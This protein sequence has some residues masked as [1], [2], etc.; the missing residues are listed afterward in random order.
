MEI[1]VYVE[2]RCAAFAFGRAYPRSGPVLIW[3][4]SVDPAC[5]VWSV[6]FVAVSRLDDFPLDPARAAIVAELG[7]TPAAR[8]RRLQDER[9]ESPE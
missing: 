1:T 6:A 2:H 9:A 8:V 5:G 7:E 4:A 3:K